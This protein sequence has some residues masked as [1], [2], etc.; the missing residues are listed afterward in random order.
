MS[1]RG[2]MFQSMFKEIQSSMHSE[3]VWSLETESKRKTTEF[4]EARARA[5]HLGMELYVNAEQFPKEMAEKRKGS[6]WD[7][8]TQLKNI[9][10]ELLDMSFPLR[11]TRITDGASK[12]KL[13]TGFRH[14]D[15]DVQAKA[16]ALAQVAAER[17]KLGKQLE[18]TGSFLESWLASLE[19]P[20]KDGYA[21][22]SIDV[23][24]V[25]YILEALG[26]ELLIFALHPAG[27]EQIHGLH[28]ADE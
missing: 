22:D 3:A 1:Y 20:E 28:P 24:E 23:P 12:E 19:G 13:A 18:R 2:R 15:K 16:V 8:L 5:I 6:D 21:K 26:N 27:G 25:T 11:T 9:A 7:A 17:R 14:G 4:Q 10:R